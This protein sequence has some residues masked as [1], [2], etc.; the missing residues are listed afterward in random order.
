MGTVVWGTDDSETLDANDGI[1]N[2]NDAIWDEVNEIWIYSGD[3]V[4]AGGGNDTVHALGGDDTVYGE[5]GN[6]TVYGDEG[7]DVLFGGDGDDELRGGDDEDYLIG[8]DGDDDLFGGRGSDALFGA[9]GRDEL[10]GR[11]DNDILIGGNDGDDLDGGGGYDWISYFGS[12]EGVYIDLDAGLAQGGAAD[13]DTFVGIEGVSGSSHDDTL[14][15]DD[16]G[17]ILY[18]QEGDDTL[19]G[20]GGSDVLYGDTSELRI[21]AY[22]YTPVYN[23][24]QN[25]AAITGNDTLYGGEGDD[26]LEGG[27]GNDILKGG[28][29]ADFLLGDAIYGDDDNGID[30]ATYTGSLAAVTV[31]LTTGEGSGGDAEGDYLWGIENLTGSS[32]ADNLIGDA[33]ANELRGAAGNDTLKGLGGADSLYG[34]DDND[35]LKGGG[36]AD[37]LDG[38]DGIDTASYEDSASGVIVS[39]LDDTA[40]G[41]DA[42]G[43]TLIA[44]E[45]LKGS[46]QADFLWGDHAANVIE[47]S[48][49]TDS[50]KGYGGDDT[51]FGGADN[52]ALIGGSGADALDGGSGLDTAS[53][54]GSYEGV[55]V[56]LLDG[57]TAFGDARGDTFVSIENLTGSI[58][59]DWLQ[60]DDGANVLNG[61]DED[62]DLLGAGGDDTLI[63][64][65][66]G[67]ELEGG[68]GA[69]VLDGGQGS[70]TAAY[71]ESAAGVTVSLRDDTASGGDAEGDE[72]DSIENLTGSAY[73]DVLTG[74]AGANILTGLDG[75]N[76][77]RGYGGDDGLFGGNDVDTLFG[78]GGVDILKGFG[79]ADTLDG[80]ANADTMLGGSADDI[81]IVDNSADVATEFVGEGA[82]DRV[83]T[84]VTYSLAAG[85]EIEV[86]ETTDQAAITALDLVG[87]EFGNIIVGN[88]GQNTIVGGLGLDTMTGWG[89]GD[90][91]VW[92]ST[93]ESGVAA[94][95]ADIVGSDFDPLTGDRLA[96]NSIDAD[97]NAGNGDTAFTFIG[98]GPLTAAGQI[99]TFTDG[100]DTYILLNTDADASQE[101]TIRVL[102]VHAV[103]ASWFV[104]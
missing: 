26:Q 55:M 40:T 7:D 57:T 18:G 56:S 48:L 63:G 58:Y 1:T 93:A 5:D 85:S 46:I 95:E 52:D 67:D 13:G 43:D 77:L 74:N 9:D 53:Y 45:N 50:L 12:T 8:D 41:G 49:G 25:F 94:N 82:F 24:L 15:G 42:E 22:D 27:R 102:G 59:H 70:D 79:G 98:T 90:I 73:A 76:T 71:I 34:E 60:G 61:G 33:G 101:M 6:D 65:E 16:A 92:S 75:D 99:N 104:L 20:G 80:G 96:L 100:F 44:I 28:A 32:Y 14:V 21:S 68:G 84:S 31:S 38:G 39:L 81:Y 3:L 30:T 72:L 54:S 88:D 86:L 91:F 83:K 87:N 64:G 11:E 62:D 78:M 29:G 23:V 2:D 69:D 51:L 103:D 97:G 10:S 89:G 47:G 35:T 66:G 17:N 4:F 36:G 37:V 19:K